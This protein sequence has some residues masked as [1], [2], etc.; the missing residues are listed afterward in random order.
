MPLPKDTIAIP[1]VKGLDLTTDARLVSPPSLL[2]AENT[3]F[4]GG[5]AKK[6]VGHQA[7]EVRGEGLT[8]LGAPKVDWVY[9]WGYTNSTPGNRPITSASVD[10]LT[11]R[12][13]EAGKLYGLAQRDS[14]TLLWSGHRAYSYTPSQDGNQDPYSAEIGNAVL[15]SLRA[16]P[17]AKSQRR[18]NF[19]DACDTGP[20]GIRLVV[21]LDNTVTASPV[22]KYS[23]YDSDT[24]ALI[25]SQATFSATKPLYA[26]CF[27]LGSWVHTMVLD[28]D[29]DTVKLHSIHVSDPNTV[30]QRSY[31]SCTGKSFDIWKHT[32]SLAVVAISDTTSIEVK[33]IGTDGSGTSGAFYNHFSY[34]V[35]GATTVTIS[36]SYQGYLGLAWYKSAG[37]EIGV[38]VTNAFGA[39]LAT[40]STLTSGSYTTTSLARLT[41]SAKGVKDTSGNDLWDLYWDNGTDLCAVRVW[42]EDGSVTKSVQKKRFRHTLAS[43]AFRVGDRTFVWAG[44]LSIIQSTWFLLDEALLPVGK[45]DFG[46]ANVFSDI[47]GG[48]TTD[49]VAS[50]NWHGTSPYESLTSLNPNYEL[51]LSYKIRA[52]P[53][54][55]SQ[56][57]E[58]IFTEPSIKWVTLNFLPRLRTVQAG[59]CLY[60]AGA[61]VWSYDGA[62]LTEAGFHIG[63]ELSTPIASA[64]GS[65]TT[66]GTYSYRVDLCYRNAQNEEVRSLSI[67]TN[68]VVLD[69]GGANRT[70]TLTI[71]TCVTRRTNSYFLIYRNAMSSGVPL[72]NW[73][74]LNSRDPGH[75]DFRSNDLSVNTVTYVDS[76]AVNDTTIQTRELHPATDTYIQ[77]IS[78]PAC[79]IIAG[80]RDRV[81]V[82]GGELLPG[83]VAPSRLF[84]P[85]ETPSWNPYLNVQVDRSSE[86]LTSIGFI[87]EVGVLMRRDATYLIDS[88]G[89]DNIAQGFW[90]PPRLAISDLGAVDQ[91]SLARISQGLIFRS[92]AGFRLL[93]PGGALTPIGMP[94]DSVARDFTVVGAVVVEKDQEVRFYGTDSTLVYNYLFDTWYRWSCG[95]TGVAK[96][97]QAQGGLALVARDDGYLWVET[98]GTYT[99]GG[100]PYSHRLRFPWLHAGNL[101]DFQRVRYVGGL[102]RFGDLEDKDHTLRL[103]FY[104]DER[105]FW[106]ERIEWTLPDTSTNQDVWGAEAWGAGVWGDT[107]A[108]VS[109]LEDL[110]WEWK[111][112]PARQKCS[113]FSVS[114]ED[115]NTTGPGFELSALTLELGLKPGLNRGPE[116]TGSGSFRGNNGL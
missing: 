20:G 64:G 75:A 59:R 98:P 95:G 74:L 58:A 68:S 69:G 14:E 51:A 113:V 2:E 12:L 47:P 70:I 45:M 90:N 24:S 100:V 92:P 96:T 48:N 38:A 107:S 35:T 37:P 1:V 50:I 54:S 82:G 32:E 11:S 99:D 112:R 43:R 102:G 57:S 114:I 106:E 76:G 101:G 71:P 109:K 7:I 80:G 40:S 26:R 17:I 4:Y 110:T 62:E 84:D 46:V 103:Q 49:F 111:R 67:L 61:Q 73:W 19:P 86:P 97:T 115:V 77:P 29:T 42:I 34:P 85:G 56:A 15:P 104:Y 66:G 89:P 72:V 63:P 13:P 16:E 41:I 22:A 6:R 18:Q 78:A 44:H 36:R 88:D 108:D 39:N 8:Q 30:V 25:V 65:L 55:V 87:G 94:T 28:D 5:G 79:E 91:E 9:G 53:T 31:G 81:W 52:N 93:G 27:S 21:W 60:I 116:R 105:E 3:R 33:W 83:Q 23:I 10:L